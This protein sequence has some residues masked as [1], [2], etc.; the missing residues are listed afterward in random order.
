MRHTGDVS[1]PVDAPGP[2]GSRFCSAFAFKVQ[3]YTAIV[4]NAD[5]KAHCF[6]VLCGGSSA[7]QVLREHETPPQSFRDFNVGGSYDFWPLTDR[8]VPEALQEEVLWVPNM[9]DP[10]LWMRRRG[11]VALEYA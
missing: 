8:Q 4:G 3:D 6:C 11:C 2:K 1:A 7:V 10:L 9:F 5:V